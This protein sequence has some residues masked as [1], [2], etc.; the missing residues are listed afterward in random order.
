MNITHAEIS[1]PSLS[2]ISV[3]NN[4][5]MNRQ[6]KTKTEKTD[7]RD[8]RRRLLP[9]P[10]N[11]SPQE[12]PPLKTAA[13]VWTT[14]PDEWPR[15]QFCSFPVAKL[16]LKKKRSSELFRIRIGTGRWID[17]I[18]VLSECL[19]CQLSHPIQGSP[20]RVDL[21]EM[22]VTQCQHPREM[23]SLDGSCRFDSLMMITYRKG[24]Q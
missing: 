3:Q 18:E 10:V 20:N 11:S 6:S 16:T 17:E 22:F 24:S 15:R 9:L 14:E 1:T 2:K 8:S 19:P 12:S 7:G 13:I 21:I 4:H 23:I 5:A